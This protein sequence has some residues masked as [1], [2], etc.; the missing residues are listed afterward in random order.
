MAWERGKRAS[1]I[2]LGSS[3]LLWVGG[4]FERGGKRNKIQKKSLLLCG[5]LKFYRN[6]HVNWTVPY[7]SPEGGS[8]VLWFEKSP[9][10]SFCRLVRLPVAWGVDGW[11]KAERSPAQSDLDATKFF[12]PFFLSYIFPPN[13]FF[14][15]LS[16]L[17]PHP[18]RGPPNRWMCKYGP[19]KLVSVEGDIGFWNCDSSF[20]FS[21]LGP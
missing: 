12:V 9:R 14:P 7:Q 18:L 5:M 20:H 16:L 1:M 2:K 8:W 11:Q 19:R 3:L 13:L 15:F 21:L 6:L 4:W 17:H 10:P